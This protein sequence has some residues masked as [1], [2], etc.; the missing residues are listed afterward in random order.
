[1]CTHAAPLLL[2][3][4]AVGCGPRGDAAS[5]D[6]AAAP[7]TGAIQSAG[8]APHPPPAA[9]ESLADS[10]ADTARGRTGGTAPPKRP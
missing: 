8:S 7:D 6:T 10:L 5:G 9:A 3:A 2:L 1:M 4:F